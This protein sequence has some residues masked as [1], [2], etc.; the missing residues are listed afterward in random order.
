MLAPPLTI[1]KEEIDFAMEVF[2]KAL[3]SPTRRCRVEALRHG[4][5]R[6]RDRF[7][8]IFLRRGQDW[9]TAKKEKRRSLFP[10]GV[11]DY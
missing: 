9:E 1:T 7:V 3:K 8:S 6:K 5:R 2:D 11:Y 4:M 10:A